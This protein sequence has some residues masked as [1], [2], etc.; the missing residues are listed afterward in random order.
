MDDGTVGVELSSG[1]AAI[2]GKFLDEVFVSLAQF[3]FRDVGDREDERGE[4]LDRSRRVG[5]ERRSLLVHW[6]S[7]KMPYNRFGV[8]LLYLAHG[9]RMA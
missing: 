5:S 6:A 2:V 9:S 1:V 8:G 4:V 7:P 3:V